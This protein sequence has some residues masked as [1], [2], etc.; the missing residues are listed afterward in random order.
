M[1]QYRGNIFFEDD[2]FTRRFDATLS[3]DNDDYYIEFQYNKFRPVDF[4]IIQGE[5]LDLGIVTFIEC[6]NCGQTSGI[7]NLVK[8]KAQHII[9]EIKFNDYDSLFATSLHVKMD[10]LK[11]WLRKPNLTGSLIFDNKINYQKHEQITLFENIEYSIKINFGLNENRQINE[12][13]TL[14]EY[15]ELEISSNKIPINIFELYNIYKKIKIFI[16]FIGIFSNKHDEFFFKEERIIYDNQ[17]DPIVMKFFTK[18]FQTTNNGILNHERINFADLKKNIDFILKNWFFDTKIQDSVVLVMEKYTFIKLTVE[19]YFLNTCFAIETFHRNNKLNYVLPKKE[20]SDLKKGIIKKLETEM[21]IK[22]FKD[23]L[24]FANEP[25]FRD[26]LNSFK[27][28]FETITIEKFDVDVFIGKIVKTRNYLVHRGSKSNILT[29][30]EIYYA[31]IYLETLTKYCIM[32]KIGIE[33]SLL[34][35]IFINTGSK[36]NQFYEMN[37]NKLV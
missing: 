36:I 28:E 22:L 15:C 23:R 10:A 4:K 34:D 37:V 2:N 12:S 9:T 33:K 16:A 20:F 8:Y 11:N 3:I 14:T 13:I 17:E 19:T 21:E 31:S 6:Y 25:S 29:N 7:I 18:N 1:K 32:E 26:R 24:Q 35:K 5:F 27:V 30:L